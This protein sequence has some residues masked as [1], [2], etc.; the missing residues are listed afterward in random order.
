MRRRVGWMYGLLGAGVLLAVAAS[1]AAGPG[2][3]FS[4]AWDAV[5]RG[6]HGTDAAT[7]IVWDLRLPRALAAILV[8][9]ALG[10]A[11]AAMQGLFQN[12]LADPYLVGASS[13]A[14]LGA[15]IAIAAGASGSLLGMG[16]QPVCAFGGALAVSLLVYGMART[17]G[18]VAVTTLLLLGIAVGS[19]ASAATSF[20]ML[21][22]NRELLEVLRFLMGS[23][24][25]AGWPQVVVV[26]I[27]LAVAGTVLLLYSREA[28]AL[29]WGD[30]AALQVG[31]EAERAK[32]VL[33]AAA[34][35]LAAA[36]VAAGGIIGFVGL[37]VPHLVRLVL[38]PSHRTLFPAAALGGGLLL[39][40]A[41]LAARNIAR[42]GELPIGIL[43]AVLGCPFFVF[44]L[45]R[46]QRLAD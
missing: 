1:L 37:V 33:L 18:R 24:S 7:T 36:A 32:L 46:G 43:T 34:T 30:E 40:L 16:I 13:G 4:A 29:L 8:G 22:A 20:L 39:L 15:T 35:L 19:L 9:A 28:D 25:A 2:L 31:V 5:I 6:P 17:T 10:L 45:L 11:G 12:P 41:D 21:R 14:A 42:P 3:R 23:L 38:G 27:C 26:L 44:L